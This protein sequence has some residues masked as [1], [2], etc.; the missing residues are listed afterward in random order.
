MGQVLAFIDTSGNSD[1]LISGNDGSLT[2]NV[3]S[4]NA[5]DSSLQIRLDNTE[6]YRFV[7][8][9]AHGAGLGIELQLK[10]NFI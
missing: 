7:D 8:T 10:D 3:D 4:S 5:N 2:I 9:A 6:E 1:A